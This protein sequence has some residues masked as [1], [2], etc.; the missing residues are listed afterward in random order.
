[1]GKLDG[2][3]AMITGGARGQGRS[4]A[5]TL[6]AAGA[7]IAVC[8]IA[9]PIGSVPYLLSTAADLAETVALVEKTGRRCIAVPADVRRPAELDAVV[10]RAVD[11]LGRIDILV[12]N[13][14][15]ASYAPLAVM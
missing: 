10:A 5:V 1:M 6:A 14:G 4:H 12:A 15:I 3:V 11:E 7:D 13:A 8:D 9:E 2:K